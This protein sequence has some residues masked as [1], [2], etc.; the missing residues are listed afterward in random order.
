MKLR[1]RLNR[2]ISTDFFRLSI[3]AFAFLFLQAC[4][5]T[6]DTASIQQSMNV[7]TYDDNAQTE[8]V[9]AQA[10]RSNQLDQSCVAKVTAMQTS[11]GETANPAQL[12][13]LATTAE[14]CVANK[15][16]SA[17]HP[18]KEK[19][20]QLTA[21]SVMNFVKAGDTERAQDNF[22][23]FTRLFPQQD[24][25]FAD[26]SSFVDTATALLSYQT[27][28]KSQ[29]MTLNINRAM[30]DDLIRQQHWLRN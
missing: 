2:L 17:E 14:R 20:M 22:E 29:L 12:Y 24:L 16:F 27:L 8:S 7:G 25:F 3:V 13:S 19:A 28:S 23:L 5:S 21:L 6:G 11:I 18:D 10:M 15:H 4:V 9:K 30:R 26:Y 1:T